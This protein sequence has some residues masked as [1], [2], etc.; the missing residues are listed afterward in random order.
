MKVLEYEA[1]YLLRHVGLPIPESQIVR[2]AQ[3]AMESPMA[4]RSFVMKAQVP[5]GGRLK[6]GSNKVWQFATRSTT[7][8]RRAFAYGGAWFS[9]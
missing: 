4:S 2:T 3:E 6:A 1:K 5:V 8:G 7:P 9:C